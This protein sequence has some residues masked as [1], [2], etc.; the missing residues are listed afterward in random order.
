MFF[1]LGETP[2]GAIPF[3]L[4]I[5]WCASPLLL[6]QEFSMRRGIVQS[7]EGYAGM[8]PDGATA[9]AS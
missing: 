7:S 9:I 8:N 6:K 3:Y 5:G 1:P 4:V 2:Y